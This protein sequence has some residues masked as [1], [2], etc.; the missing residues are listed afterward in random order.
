ME[1]EIVK[2]L[3]FGPQQVFRH[4]SAVKTAKRLPLPVQEKHFDRNLQYE[5]LIWQL[6]NE[7]KEQQR[8]ILF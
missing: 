4:R 8:P 1:A 6:E 3:N 5:P 2:N 7:S